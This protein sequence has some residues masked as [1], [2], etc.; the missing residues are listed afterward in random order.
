MITEFRFPQPASGMHDGFAPTWNGH[1][2]SFDLRESTIFPGG[3]GVKNPPAMQEMQVWSPGQE[4]P[5]EKE[6]ATHSSI[7]AWETP[8]TEEPGEQQFLGSQSRTW[9]SN[10]ANQQI[11]REAHWCNQTYTVLWVRTPGSYPQ[12]PLPNHCEVLGLSSLFGLSFS[13]LQSEEFLLHQLHGE[14]SGSTLRFFLS[15]CRKEKK[16]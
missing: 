13:P 8:W 12:A 16:K 11:K 15:F 3:S 10:W 1:C 2:A 5:L 14:G 7:L 4:D 6:M 9:L